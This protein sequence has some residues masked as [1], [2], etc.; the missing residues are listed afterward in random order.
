MRLEVVCYVIV[1]GTYGEMEGCLDPEV[2]GAR[3]VPF[4]LRVDIG[5]CLNKCLDAIEAATLS[6]DMKDGLAFRV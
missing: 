2:D 1:L 5:T 4:L 3:I 6:G